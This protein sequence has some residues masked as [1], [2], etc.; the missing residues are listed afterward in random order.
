[1]E[2]VGYCVRVQALEGYGDKIGGLTLTPDYVAVLATRHT[3]AGT[4]E[5]PH[6]HIVIRTEIKAQAFRVR[7]KKLFPDGK[8]NAHMSIVPWDGDDRALS[9]LFHEDDDN[10]QL[11]ARKGVSDEQITEYKQQNATV[12]VLVAESKKKA[13]STLWEDALIYFR[14]NPKEERS[15][16]KI[17]TYM[18]LHALRTGKYPPPRWQV[19]GM[20]ARVQFLLLDGNI[21]KEEKFAEALAKDIFERYT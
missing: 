15:D 9:Y 3:G 8:G 18:F 1:M 14:A 21:D 19:V 10:T 20:V 12:K 13:S 17:G 2:T 5:N 7:M 11:A 4:K 6:Y 16:V